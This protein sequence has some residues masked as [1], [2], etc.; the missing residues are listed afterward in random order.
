MDLGT[1]FG[2]LIG[3]LIIIFTVLT[4]N[5]DPIWF[6]DFGSVLIVLGGTLSATLVNYPLRNVQALLRI[7]RAAFKRQSIE[8]LNIIEQLID[9][10]DISR[11]KG[12]L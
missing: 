5:G 1:A 2:L 3:M 7:L 4:K 6:M 8:H 9:K 10:A 11:K 12:I